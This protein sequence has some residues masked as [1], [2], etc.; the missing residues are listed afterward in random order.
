LSRDRRASS[1]R[2][3]RTFRIIFAAS[4]ALLWLSCEGLSPVL[5]IRN[6]YAVDEV[7]ATV[8][9]ET[10]LNPDVFTEAAVQRGI[11]RRRVGRIGRPEGDV[12]ML[13]VP[14]FLMVTRNCWIELQGGTVKS[15][16]NFTREP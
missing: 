10:A 1:S 16:R 9:I 5:A 2:T 6:K 4:L 3:R 15:V 14:L 7:C 12:L 11:E 8:R 13:S